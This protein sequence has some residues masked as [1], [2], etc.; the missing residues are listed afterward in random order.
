MINDLEICFG[1]LDVHVFWREEQILS[2]LECFQ[3]K[4]E[5]LISNVWMLMLSG[6]E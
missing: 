2:C 3:L 6:S 5:N 1:V 4:T